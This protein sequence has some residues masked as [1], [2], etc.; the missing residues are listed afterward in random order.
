MNPRLVGIAGPLKGV[1]FRLTEAEISVG[2]D[3]SNQLCMS[4]PSVSRQ[5]C[6]ISGDDAG[7][8]V[9][10]L[11]S[12]NGT[13]VNDLPVG[14]RPLAHGDSLKVGDYLFIFLLA[15][16]DEAAPVGPVRFE[17][18]GPDYD[19]TVLLRREGALYAAPEKMLAALSPRQPRLARELGAL[20]KLGAALDAARD[21]RA[22]AERLL[23]AAEEAVPAERGAVL[24]AGEGDVEPTEVFGW[25][26]RPGEPVVVSRTVAGRALREGVAILNTRVQEG[27]EADAAP[28][29]V[30]SQAQSLLAVPLLARGRALGL[31]YLVTGDPEARFDE[32]HLRFM[33]AIAG[34]G[35]VALGQVRHMAQVEDEAR[36][37]RA[38][39]D[40]EHQMVGESPRMREVYRL[41]AKVA[42]SDAT[43]MVRGESGTGKELVARALHLNSPRAARPFVAV[44]CAAL[45]ETLLESELF[46][47]EKGAFTG[48]VAQKKGKLEAADG[49]TVFLDEIGEMAP[50]MQAHLLR[51]LQEHEFERVGGTR[52]IKVD[53]RV[54]AATNR[55]L[56]AAI[57]DGTFRA[58]LYYRLNVVSLM[59]PPLR[60]RRDDIPLLASY[61]AAKCARKCRRR[62]RGVSPA[63]R[64]ALARYDW[65]GNVRELENAIERA[66][67]LGADELVL[68]EDLPES[69]IDARPPGGAPLKYYEILRESKRQLVRR[70]VVEA[71]GN[72]AEAARLLGMHPNNLHRLLRNLDL[73]AGPVE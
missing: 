13:F 25:S 53:I 64:A 19:T 3:P 22:L 7:F 69:V 38:E 30:A 5:H 8:K 16:D 33:T 73:K 66:V 70:A 50:A 59:L 36:R 68:A 12:R 43:V 34:M 45:T 41:I 2:R 44:N 40:I 49:G 28:S 10:D 17:E 56:E 55:D 32:G 18:G 11:N 4:D 42:P 9:T 46:G 14:Q 61:F 23:A 65:P 51:V 63:A 54:I 15:E 6:L 67:V 48:A 24:L 35:A 27:G 52:P 58:D 29:L 31:I 26:R 21:V 60:E 57:E 47:H 72:V 37:L 71:R 1:V 39:I 62:V 20:L